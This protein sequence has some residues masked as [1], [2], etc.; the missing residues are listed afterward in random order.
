MINR[1]TIVD[2]NGQIVAIVPVQC[3]FYQYTTRF[4]SLYTISSPGSN[5]NIFTVDLLYEIVSHK[6]KLLIVGQMYETIEDFV[7]DC[8]VTQWCVHC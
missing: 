1:A 2:H 3:R 7:F 5:N 6:I 4:L 8:D